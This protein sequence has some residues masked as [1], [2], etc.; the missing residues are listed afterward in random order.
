MPSN[1]KHESSSDG[2]ASQ[3]HGRIISAGRPIDN[4]ARYRISAY[5]SGS[6]VDDTQSSDTGNLTVHLPPHPLERHDGHLVVYH[7]S[8]IRVAE[9]TLDLENSHASYIE[10]HAPAIARAQAI[11][12]REQFSLFYQAVSWVAQSGYFTKHHGVI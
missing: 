8:G 3:V 9:V 12:S 1:L 5:L 2:H 4:F 6:I 10:I 7:R 11:V